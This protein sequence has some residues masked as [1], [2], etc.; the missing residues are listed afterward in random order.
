M[1][2]HQHPTHH[3]KPEH[4]DDGH[5]GHDGHGGH[6]KHAGHDPE[7]FRRLF[8]WNL[9]LAIPVLV[10]SAQIQDWFDYSIDANWGAWVAPVIGTAI[11]LW[12]GR[13]FLAGGLAEVRNRQPGMM[14]LIT[15][16]IT[17]AYVSSLASSLGWGD[18]DFWWELAA[19]IVVMLL[20][21]WQEMK[22]IGQAQG[23]LAALAEL[24]PDSAERVSGDSVD[25]V[26]IADLAVDD[27]VLVRPG[28]RVPADGVIVDGRAALDESMITGESRPVTR[29][30]G[31]RVVAGTV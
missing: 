4:A 6:D 31:D 26:A 29:G 27:V 5:R 1:E 22:A 25:E 23:A 3:S 21:H 16:A 2:T 13:P 15:L 11:Y 10:V 17:V 30:D 9:V 12:G 8:W 18:L 19:L 20:G 7:V 24:L 28:G 14:L